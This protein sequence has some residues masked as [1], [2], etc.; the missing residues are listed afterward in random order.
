VGGCVDGSADRG[1]DGETWDR[2]TAYGAGGFP[3]VCVA[4][5][6]QDDFVGFAHLVSRSEPDAEGIRCSMVASDVQVSIGRP[7]R[8][9][10]N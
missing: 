7:R 10:E 4:H 5:A 9:R 6:G 1:V 2:A 8:C 3:N